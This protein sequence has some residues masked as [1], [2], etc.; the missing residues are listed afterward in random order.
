MAAPGPGPSE[1]P[2]VDKLVSIPDI[3]KPSSLLT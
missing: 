3:E 2:I 1:G